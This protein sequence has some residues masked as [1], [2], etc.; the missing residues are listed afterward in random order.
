[1]TKNETHTSDRN[2]SSEQIRGNERTYVKV[3]VIVLQAEHRG[4]Q[5]HVLQSL[6]TLLSR[7]LLVVLHLFCNLASD[8]VFDVRE[9]GH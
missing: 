2:H 3:H 4:K 8:L 6:K 9:E 1:M 5:E 7:L